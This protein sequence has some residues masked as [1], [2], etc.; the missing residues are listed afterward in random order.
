LPGHISLWI[1]CALLMFSGCASLGVDTAK[2]MTYGGP[3]EDSDVIESTATAPGCK[4]ACTCGEGSVFEASTAQVCSRGWEKRLRRLGLTYQKSP[5][6]VLGVFPQDTASVDLRS[7][8][9]E[10]IPFTLTIVSDF[11]PPWS[12][13]GCP[14]SYY[15]SRLTFDNPEEA[16]KGK[17]SLER[18]EMATFVDSPRR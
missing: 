7:K 17:A 16:A 13:H 10:G 3:Q 15:R 18:L 9:P 11:G 8:T 12:G 6:D 14:R 5:P 1:T 4:L 2:A